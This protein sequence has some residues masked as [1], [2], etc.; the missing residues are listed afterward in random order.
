M[1]K[2]QRPMYC[3]Q[4]VTENGHDN[5]QIGGRGFDRGGVETVV[6]NADDAEKGWW[7]NAMKITKVNAMDLW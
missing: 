7:R 4:H 6:E 1:Q 3:E 2:L 5:G